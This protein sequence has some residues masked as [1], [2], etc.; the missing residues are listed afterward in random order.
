MTPPVLSAR[1]EE[2]QR[3]FRRL[4]HAF[5]RP[6]RCVRIEPLDPQAPF[7]AALALGRCLLDEAV[8]C[9]VVGPA[10]TAEGLKGLLLQE[11]RARAAEPEKADFLWICGVENA[12]GWSTRVCRGSAE[13]PQEGA[14]VVC[15]LGT[16]GEASSAQRLPVRLAGPGIESASGIAPEMEGIPLSAWEELQ[17]VNAEFPCG[18]DAV[19]LQPEGRLMAVPRSIRI[20]IGG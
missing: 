10:G 19:F 3:V 6:G 14:T 15:C 2:S 5:S 1:E 8:S 16:P 13:A 11:T 20:R 7:A 9:A 4:L 18:V 17:A 12:A